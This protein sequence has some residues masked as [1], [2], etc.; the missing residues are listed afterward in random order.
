M[1]ITCPVSA[2]ISMNDQGSGI[3]SIIPGRFD[4]RM[5]DLG[6]QVHE[7]LCANAQG[8]FGVDSRNVMS[9]M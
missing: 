3:P 9:E 5:E 4:L 7:F 8:G 2:S 6:N 1:D